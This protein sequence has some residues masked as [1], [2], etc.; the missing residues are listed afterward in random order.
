MT[1]SALRV[2]SHKNQIALEYLLRSAILSPR[3]Q[4]FLPFVVT[5]LTSL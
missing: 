5:V 1:P 3:F 4:T 2:V